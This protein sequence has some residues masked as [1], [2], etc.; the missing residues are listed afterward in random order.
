MYYTVQYTNLMNEFTQY[1]TDGKNAVKRMID[2]VKHNNIDI[3]DEVNL[4][5]MKEIL[6]HLCGYA[7]CLEIYGL[8]EPKT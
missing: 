5:Q 7:E 2:Y 1:I 4:E 3:P 8:I 6:I